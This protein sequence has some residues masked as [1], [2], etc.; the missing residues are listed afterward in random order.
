[1]KLQIHHICKH[2]LMS[3]PNLVHFDLR[4]TLSVLIVY[5]LLQ[6]D[7]KFAGCS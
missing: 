1:M 4:D 6:V 3:F 5:V 7:G 2:T